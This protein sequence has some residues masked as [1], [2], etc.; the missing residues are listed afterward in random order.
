MDRRRRKPC[1]GGDRAADLVTVA[2]AHLR[3]MSDVIKSMS[4]PASV[5][6]TRLGYGAPLRRTRPGVDAARTM[7]SSHSLVVAS[8]AAG[9]WRA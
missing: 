9:Y 6:G 2:A 7:Q 5:P 1:Q 8:I 3:R 4:K